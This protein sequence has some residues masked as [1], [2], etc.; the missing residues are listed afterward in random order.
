VI[1][2]V[3]GPLG[4]HGH[5]AT[6]LVHRF[7]QHRVLANLAHWNGAC[8]CDGHSDRRAPQDA[9]L[10]EQDAR[11]ELDRRIERKGDRHRRLDARVPNVSTVRAAHVDDAN[12]PGIDHDRRVLARDAGMLDAQIAFV[13]AADEDAAASGQGQRREAAVPEHE[14][15][16]HSVPTRP[17]ERVARGR[18]A[19]SR[20][21][22]GH[23]V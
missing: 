1:K 17:L 4:D 15:S 21:R 8:G 9:A 13:A 14:D 11:T 3:D 7:V 19:R 18:L 2:H 16:I 20:L 5:Q 12:A 23:A 22:V 6:Q 10:N